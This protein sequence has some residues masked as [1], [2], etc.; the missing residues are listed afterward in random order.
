[1]A[2]Y[3]F[4]GGASARRT[5]TRPRRREQNASVSTDT[6]QDLSHCH[7]VQ[8]CASRVVCDTPSA[9]GGGSLCVQVARKPVAPLLNSDSS[10][11]PSVPGGKEGLQARAV[12]TP[13]RVREPG[14]PRGHGPCRFWAC[15]RSSVPFSISRRPQ[16]GR[17]PGAPGG[18]RAVFPAVGPL[19]PEGSPRAGPSPRGPDTLCG[20]CLG[21]TATP[22]PHVPCVRGL[23]HPFPGKW[24]HL[25]EFVGK[26]SCRPAGDM[27]LGRATFPPAGV[28][29]RASRQ[30]TPH[31][32]QRP[33]APAA[34]S[35]GR[36]AAWGPLRP[37][38][39]CAVVR[40][41]A[42]LG[43]PTTR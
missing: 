21:F 29:S 3:L 32:L 15:V 33:W 14:S 16:T 1:M 22:S 27:G 17:E 10:V 43:F 24:G 5:E 40:G 39:V 9:H 36:A 7:G 18:A 41:P 4:L 35:S 23:L 19:L 6:N 31:G 38:G 28:P 34:A 13:A 11:V 12:V 26:P 42:R 30:W 25:G 2:T 8:T 20:L 37:A